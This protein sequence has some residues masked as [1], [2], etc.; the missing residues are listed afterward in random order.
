MANSFTKSTMKKRLSKR[1]GYVMV[2]FEPGGALYSLDTGETIPRRLGK[3]ITG[4][5]IAPK[6]GDLFLKPA[7]DGLFPGFSQTY[8]HAS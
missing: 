1:P 5:M 8:H 7:E 3:E 2:T 6:S 4:G